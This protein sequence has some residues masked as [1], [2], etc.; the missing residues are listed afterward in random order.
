MNTP[1]PLDRLEIKPPRLRFWHILLAGMAFVLLVVLA[2]G[3][4]HWWRVRRQA[5]LVKQIEAAGGQV[6]YFQDYVMGPDG[7]FEQG[8]APSLFSDDFR[9]KYP[10][11]CS[12]VFGVRAWHTPSFE[13]PEVTAAKTEKFFLAAKEFPRLK[14]VTIWSDSLDGR[15]L[16]E[17]KSLRGLQLLSIS[18]DQITDAAIPA[19]ITAKNLRGL[20]LDGSQL[21]NAALPPLSKL[22]RLK[23]FS[24]SSP[25]ITD[26]GM[27]H[28]QLPEDLEY[29]SFSLP[30]VTDKGFCSLPKFPRLKSLSVNTAIGDAG[31]A[32]LAAGGQLDTLI[33]KKP[34]FGDAGLAAIA[35]N[36]SLEGILS[37]EDSAITDEGLRHLESLPG[38]SLLQLSG[39]KITDAGLS[40]LTAMVNLQKVF[41][42][43]TQ[44]TGAGLTHLHGLPNLDAIDLSGCP[45]TDDGWSALQGFKSLTYLNLAGI[46][47]T[48]QDC[49]RIPFAKPRLE[50]RSSY[51]LLDLSRTKITDACV[52]ALIRTKFRRITLDNTALTD[53]AL[54]AI[55]AEPGE[56]TDV[57]AKGTKITAHG[58]VDFFDRIRAAG[59]NC[60]V[61]SDIPL[62]ELNAI[63]EAKEAR[64]P[65]AAGQ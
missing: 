12:Q 13:D 62:E 63:R 53:A 1:E 38:V 10:N 14:T 56:L 31:I 5:E 28:L 58:V 44:V 26:A 41:L 27:A 8:K 29:L 24:L 17:M 33:M 23:G 6:F 19:V 47:I 45:I 4:W 22:T 61:S 9:E 20:S 50:D 54:L 32:H 2:L 51:T 34:R 49:G 60:F 3:T 40:H 7:N 46:P 18:G 25:L 11:F 65:A 43:R 36:H 39:T 21:T 55:A 16:S 30:V 15:R 59:H 52:P 64:N 57:S 42:A 48:D 35:S 37:L